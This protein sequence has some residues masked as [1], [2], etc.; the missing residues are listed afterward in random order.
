[1]SWT[2]S[3]C[4]ACFLMPN[5]THTAKRCFCKCMGLFVDGKMIKL[6]HKAIS[7]SL[8]FRNVAFKCK[9]KT[10]D[11]EVPNQTWAWWKE[12]VSSSFG[13]LFFF[14]ICFILTSVDKKLISNLICD[15]LAWQTVCILVL[16]VLVNQACGLKHVFCHVLGPVPGTALTR[17]NW[18]KLR[19]PR[20]RLLFNCV[21]KK[22]QKERKYTGFLF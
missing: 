6:A 15:L 2:K 3:E 1:M 13:W 11:D 4:F 14:L 19:E 17:S 18:P 20:L 21:K 16:K 10:K 7:C 22:Y 5:G 8:F 12:I 9:W